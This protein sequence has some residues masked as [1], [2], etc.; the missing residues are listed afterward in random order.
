MFL[1][2]I[3]EDVSFIKI[4]HVFELRYN[5]LDNGNLSH[6]PLAESKTKQLTAYF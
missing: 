2:N 5:Q 3:S 6:N 1:W 4:I